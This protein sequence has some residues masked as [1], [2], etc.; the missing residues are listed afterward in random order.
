LQAYDLDVAGTY[1]LIVSY[2]G[3][4]DHSPVDSANAAAGMKWRQVRPP[5]AD[6]V[7]LVVR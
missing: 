3:R 6:T 4:I 7:V 1:N 2:F 5:L